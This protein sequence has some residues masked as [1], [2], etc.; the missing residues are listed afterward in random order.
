MDRILIYFLYVGCQLR[1]QLLTRDHYLM[2]GARA[3]L[4]DEVQQRLPQIVTL[5][6]MPPVLLFKS[7]VEVQHQDA[8]H[9][10]YL[11]GDGI[12][13]SRVGVIHFFD[14][15]PGIRIFFFSSF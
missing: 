12:L 1:E 3:D 9:P 11:L 14:I 15:C 10:L 13:L 8:A 6:K 5:S 4:L 7:V 2:L